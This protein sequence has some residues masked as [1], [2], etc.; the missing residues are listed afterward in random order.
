M[1]KGED[2]RPRFTF[3]ISEEQQ[4]RANKLLTT[5]GLRRAIM[6]VI[7]DD[8]LDLVEKHGQIVVG[9]MLD[10]AAKPRE[11]LPTMAKAERKAK[12]GTD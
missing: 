6:S 11:I 12:D 9:V 3:E 7:L 10:G 4:L 1:S 2:F 5:F 8:L